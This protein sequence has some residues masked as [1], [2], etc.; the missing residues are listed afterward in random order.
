M[1]WF[2]S[3]AGEKG[4]A[5]AQSYSNKS[6]ASENSIQWQM[7]QR[8]FTH[9]FY[10][11]VLPHLTTFPRIVLMQNYNG[12]DLGFGFFYDYIISE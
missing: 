7:S 8:S 12:E 3:K 11:K 6:G 10:T 2:S 5:I 9:P 1:N 4:A